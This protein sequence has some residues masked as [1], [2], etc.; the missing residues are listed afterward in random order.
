MCLTGEYES[1]AHAYA[2]CDKMKTK[3]LQKTQTGRTRKKHW[4]VADNKFSRKNKRKE[5]EKESWEKEEIVVLEDNMRFYAIWRFWKSKKQ[6]TEATQDE[7]MKTGKQTNKLPANRS[8]GK[9][10]CVQLTQ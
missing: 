7:Q 6:T 10:R 4:N 2:L 3:R 8:P 5:M 9:C 1:T